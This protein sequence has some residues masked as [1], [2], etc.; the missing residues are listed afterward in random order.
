MNNIKSSLPPNQIYKES[1]RSCYQELVL[2]YIIEQWSFSI[3]RWYKWLI[4]QLFERTF[5][6]TYHKDGARLNNPDQNFELIFRENNNCHQIG[7]AYLRKD[8]TMWKADIPA[9]PPNPPDPDFFNGDDIRLVGTT[10]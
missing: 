3:K 8:I 6:K 10:L 7:K 5:S 1:N 4:L 9:N 2:H